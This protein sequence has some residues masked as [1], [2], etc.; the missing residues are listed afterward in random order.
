[1]GKNRSKFV[2]IFHKNY[3]IQEKACVLGEILSVYISFHKLYVKARKKP[4]SLHRQKTINS[5]LRHKT[6]IHY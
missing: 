5:S 4:L 3:P 1:L 2:Q 6:W